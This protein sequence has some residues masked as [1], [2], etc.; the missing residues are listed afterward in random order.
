MSAGTPTERAAQCYALAEAAPDLRDKAAFRAAAY[1]WE[2]I[3]KPG[4]EWSLEPLQRELAAL[5]AL[6]VAPLPEPQRAAPEPRVIFQRPVR[7]EL[8]IFEQQETTHFIP[9]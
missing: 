6:T 2:R 9:F 7:P 4:V 8:R 3:S 5:K 1:A